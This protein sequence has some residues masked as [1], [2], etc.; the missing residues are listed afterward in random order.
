MENKMLFDYKCDCGNEEID[1]Y[2][3]NSEEI[4]TCKSCGNTMV[5]Q[6]PLI[7]FDIKSHEICKYKNKFGNNL[8]PNYKPTGGA[9]FVPPS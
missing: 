6:M 3:H 9:N 4:I 8:P 1:V 5:K 2:V 7:S